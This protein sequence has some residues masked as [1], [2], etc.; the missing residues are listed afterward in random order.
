MN[1][2]WNNNPLTV[3]KGLPKGIYALF[4]ARIVDNAGNFIMPLIT[5]ILTQKIC[6]TKSQT[7]I[8]ATVFMFSQA[9]FLLLGGWLV[10]KAG[11]K[12][13]IVVFNFLGAFFY[14]I[15]GFLKPNIIMALF[16]ALAANMFAVASPALNSIVPEIV[17]KKSL[18]NS[19]SLTYLGYNLGYAFGPAIAGMLFNRHLNLLFFLDAATAFVSVFLIFFLVN[20]KRPEKNAD[21]GLK[22]DRIRPSGFRFLLHAPALLLFSA[23]FLIYNFCFSQ[24]SFV[25]PLQISDRFMENGARYYSLLVTANA[26]SVIFLTPLLTPLTHKF[27]SLALIGAGG[28]FYMVSFLL[29]GF[30][31]FLALFFVA[32]VIMT[33]GQI[34]ININSTIYIAQRTPKRY[35]GT[36]NS[37]LSIITGLGIAVGPVVMGNVLTAVHYRRAW[38]SIAAL[39]LF[40]SAAMFLLNRKDSARS[41]K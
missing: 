25:L 6:L 9:P 22:K 39:M 21:I 2:K 30:N 27:R 29:Y 26:L 38:L 34:F 24:W 4:F 5:L 1:L 17:P 14:I 33:V 11:S 16:I 23:A 18:K 20:T 28:I 3:Y 35:L 32:A 10:D 19:Y 8:Y 13:V 15:C 37:L 12:K 31:R 40:G 36:A 41:G 7:G